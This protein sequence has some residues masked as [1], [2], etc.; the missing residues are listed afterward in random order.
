MQGRS[1]Y[2]TPDLACTRCRERKIRCGRERPECS[3]CERDGGATCVY[4][5]P[6][7]RVNHIKL[8]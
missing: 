2:T 5:N 4:Q 1:E 6:A 8:L 7:K 3:N